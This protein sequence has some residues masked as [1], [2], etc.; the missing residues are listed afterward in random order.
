MAA[1]TIRVSLLADAKNFR[2]GMAQADASL[3]QTEKKAGTFG[4]AMDQGKAKMQN[5]AKFAVA[6][7]AVGAGAALVGFLTDA[8]KAA[9]ED[10]K[11]QELL[12]LAI[13]N[14]TGATDKQVEAVEAFIEK[15]ALAS[16]VADDELR[17]ALA[18]L[19][20]TTGDLDTAQQ[21]LAV[22]M[23][24]AAAKGKPLEAVTAAIG[25]AALGNIGAL[26]RLGVKTKDL[27]GNTLSL[28]EVMAEASKTMGD[29]SEVAAATDAGSMA[30]LQV[31][32]GEMKEE[33]GEGLIPVLVSLGEG[34]GSLLDSF[35]A[36]EDSGKPV[37]NSIVDWFQSMDEKINIFGDSV[38]GTDKVAGDFIRT[39]DDGRGSQVGFTEATEDM[40][41]AEDELADEVKTTSD[42]IQEQFDL[43]DNQLD[44][45]AKYTG[46]VDDAAE[47]QSK[48]NAA[49]AEFGE[50]SPEHIEA[51]E[52][53]ASATRD[54]KAAELE[55]LGAGGMTREEFKKQR[56]AMG[57]TAAEADI[58]I[59]K[60]EN[61]FTPRS[62]NHRVNIITRG[63]LNADPTRRYAGRASGGPVSRGR[64]YTV[65]ETGPETFVPSTNGSIIRNGAGM[66]GGVINVTV[67][68]L[69]PQGAAKAVVQALQAYER[70]NGAIPVTVRTP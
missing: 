49:V 12:K 55:L 6:G 8:T 5:F 36:L 38:I 10:L 65:G 1:N 67:N 68:A 64:V 35:N 43:I 2:S 22:A 51:L 61:L 50:G 34:V 16:G 58:L 47:A 4:G 59:A 14:T 15:T 7:L 11:A 40:S 13:Q 23:D 26:G 17:P 32:F 52:E 46:A 27:E 62:V 44:T 3:A 39:L 41:D 56:V 21:F 48:V 45:F 57:L 30:R 60:Y 19:V 37:V 69:D 63:D 20:R 53:K 42:R 54:V 66:G 28:S 29:A 25:K 24:I 33:V 9:M 31:R 18:E 70:S